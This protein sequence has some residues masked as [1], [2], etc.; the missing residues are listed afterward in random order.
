MMRAVCGSTVLYPCDPNQTAEL[1]KQMADIKGIS[2]LRTTREKT[3]V[4]YPPK[5]AFPVG[6]SHVLKK[7]AADKVAVVAA[8]I[9]VHE[10][11]KAHET[12]AKAGIAVRLIDAYSV[13]PIDRE[14]LRQAAK[15]TGGRLVVVEDHWAEGG[16][17]DAVLEAFSG[18]EGPLPRVVKLGV[19]KMPGSGTPWQLLDAAG[20]SASHIVEAV[21]SLL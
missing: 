20:I 3:P 12:L 14:T 18:V 5:T 1:V 16:L 21:K 6:K 13:K 2:Y 19:R 15:D 10:A 9:T 7:S 8:G 11:L 17:G 4:L